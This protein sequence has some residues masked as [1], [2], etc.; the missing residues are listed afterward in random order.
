MQAISCAGSIDNLIV[1]DQ[2][3]YKS[4]VYTVAATV[5]EN[6]NSP[7]KWKVGELEFEALMRMLDNL[8]G[9]TA[10]VHDLILTLIEPPLL[11]MSFIVSFTGLQNRL[12]LPP[13]HHAREAEAQERCGDPRHRHCVYV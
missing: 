13:S 3:K 1:L 2:E 10:A 11:I 8:V 4:R 12:H 9:Q 6:M 7:F 5:S